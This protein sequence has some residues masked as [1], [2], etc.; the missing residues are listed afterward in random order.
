MS[1]WIGQVAK[2]LGARAEVRFTHAFGSGTGRRGRCRRECGLEVTVREQQ[3][4][5]MK[6][7]NG[8]GEVERYDMR[9]ANTLSQ[10]C[11]RCLHATQRYCVRQMCVP[12]GVCVHIR[13]L[14]WC[15]PCRS[16]SASSL[17][18]LLAKAFASL[19]IRGVDHHGIGRHQS[20]NLEGC[21]TRRTPLR[22][23]AHVDQPCSVELRKV[24]ERAHPPERKCPARSV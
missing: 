5:R 2:R 16:S 22:L 12:H 20:S 7:E 6:Y 21:S 1:A 18:V 23:A 19:A 15:S 9:T 4:R 10:A 3:G 14:L 13:Q 11:A 8:E 17:G 24:S